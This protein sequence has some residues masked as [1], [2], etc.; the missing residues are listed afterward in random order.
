M[1]VMK[2]NRLLIFVNEFVRENWVWIE[3][4]IMIYLRNGGQN[5]KFG[6]WIDDGKGWKF[7]YWVAF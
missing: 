1:L 6:E 5:V 2:L 7:S 4:K 3:I